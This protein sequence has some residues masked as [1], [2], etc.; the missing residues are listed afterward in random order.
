MQVCF[1]GIIPVFFGFR[2][3]FPGTWY[4][5]PRGGTF[6]RIMQRFMKHFAE[7]QYHPSNLRACL[8]L[9]SHAALN[10]QNKEFVFVHFAKSLAMF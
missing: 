3:T 2:N 8:A 5:I 1:T 9:P 10:I 6:Y 7:T 4:I